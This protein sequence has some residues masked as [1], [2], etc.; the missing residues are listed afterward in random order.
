VSD[1]SVAGS[2]A[3]ADVGRRVDRACDRFEAAWRAGERPSIEAH[4]AGWEGEARAALLRELILLDADYRRGHGEPVGPD[5]YLGRFPELSPTWLAGALNAEAQA[6]TAT[7]PPANDTLPNGPPAPVRHIGDYEVLEEIARGGMGVVF[8]ARQQSPRRV[9]ALKMILAG[10]LA[11][12]D[13]VRRFRMEAENAASLEHPHI[14]PIYEV[15]E[16]DGQPFFSMKFIG[17]GTLAQHV[18]RLTPDPRAAAR[19]MATVARAVHFAHQRGILH[20]DLKPGNI[21]LDAE[22]QPHVTDFGLAKRVEDGK[23]QTL[24]GAVVGTPGY[25]APE[26][27]AGKKGLTW[28]ADVHGLGAVLYALLTSRPPFQAETQIDTILQTLED[29]PV[30]PSRR[31]PGVPRDLEVICLKC[32]SKEPGKRY[33]NA[34]ALADEL[35]RY[36]AGKPITG[37][38]VGRVERAVKWVRRRPVIAGLLTLVVLVTSAGTTGMLWQY[39]HAVEARDLADREAE[40]A[41]RL[42]SKE[43]AARERAD[44]ERHA[45]LMRDAL[46]AWERHDVAE[47]ERVLGEVD[48]SFQ[49]TWET[50]HLR[51]L[52]RRK[53]MPLLGHTGWVDSVAFSPDGQR[54]VSGSRDATVRVWEAATGREVLCL[55]GHTGRVECIAFSPDGQR[56]I[57]GSGNF[58]GAGRPLPG[59]VKVWDAKQGRELLSLRTG[60]VRCVAFSPDGQR[61]ASGDADGTVHVWDPATGRE[62]LFRKVHR[63]IVRSLVFIPDRQRIASVGGD[64]AVRVWEVATGR[65]VLSGKGHAG[66]VECVAFRA[67]GQRFV[68]GYSDGTVRVWETATGREVLCLKGHGG[69]VECVAFSPDGQRIVSGGA[70]GAARV[71]DAETGRELFPLVAP[72]DGNL[73]SVAFSPDGQRFV[74]GFSDGTLRVC[75]AATSQEKVSLNGHDGKVEVAFSPDSKRVV[76]GDVAGS[77]RVW[78][79]AT[80]QQI[81]S[82]KGHTDAVSSIAF[83]PDGQRV[84]SGGGDGVLRVWETVTGRQVLSLKGHNGTVECVAFSPDGKQIISGNGGEDGSGL[85]L[86]GEVKVWDAENGRELLSLKGHTGAVLNVAFSPDGQRIVSGGGDRAVRKWEVATGRQVLSIKTDTRAVV[87]GFSPDGQILFRHFVTGGTRYGSPMAVSPDGKRFAS[88][89]NDRAVWDLATGQQVSS[90]QG[91]KYQVYGLAISV[92]FSPDGQRIVTGGGNGAIRVWNTATGQEMLCFEGHKDRVWSVA[93][94]PDGQRIV[95][96]SDDGTVKIWDGAPLT[97]MPAWGAQPAGQ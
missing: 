46:S 52:C 70:G 18:G 30:P 97:E 9:V 19:L 51:G 88:V 7:L 16:H 86:P 40:A 27:A 56:I 66:I 15:G 5:D 28:A 6:A 87:E 17:G 71:W 84:V 36:L 93:F 14:V 81:L 72:S 62:V 33:A 90:L 53:A 92:A 35:E 94:S 39:G 95:S 12:A 2:A 22:G 29:E 47:A 44:H 4:A 54:I 63:S 11:D 76:S 25:L 1:P 8:K 83:S 21:L 64:G 58:D 82:L 49:Q 38:P 41:R 74:S 37:R 78:E 91:R 45:L 77:V 13:Q 89:G 10:A 80:G 85:A 67:D 3:P 24:S 42:A 60:Y 69:T 43:K 34:E 32:L 48:E 59:E 55:K 23:G 26:Q 96:A 79:V 61:I 20:R 57:S 31:R 50:R 73:L 75:R 68:S 65:E